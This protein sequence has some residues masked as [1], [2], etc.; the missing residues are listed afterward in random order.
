VR[1]CG[2]CTFCCKPLAIEELQKP[3]GILCGHCKPGVG[4]GIYPDRPEACRGFQCAWLTTDILPEDWRPDK[5]K[6]MVVGGAEA[7]V[8]TMWVS[9]FDRLTKEARLLADALV[10]EG[11]MVI[12]AEGDKRRALVPK[13]FAGENPYVQIVNKALDGRE[14]VLEVPVEVGGQQVVVR[15]KT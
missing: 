13:S 1:S 3:A 10:A 6:A 14:T 7:K 5:I 4:C 11:N 8:L 15:R 9:Y 2:D 12:L